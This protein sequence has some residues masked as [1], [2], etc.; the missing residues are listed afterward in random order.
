MESAELMQ[1]SGL[2]TPDDVAARLNV[3]RGMVY[4][5]VRFGE[6]RVVRVGR[7]LRIPATAVET[8]VQRGGGGKRT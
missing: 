1:L 4:R 8:F 5:L 2:L 6:L 7:L 3:P